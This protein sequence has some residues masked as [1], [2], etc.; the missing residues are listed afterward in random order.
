MDARAAACTPE[1]LRLR[2]N[3]RGLSPGNKDRYFPS[4]Q[5]DTLPLE[6]DTFGE[7][8]SFSGTPGALGAVELITGT[9]AAA[10]RTSRVLI[11]TNNHRRALNYELS[12]GPRFFHGKVK[13]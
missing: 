9:Q 11:H 10:A 5:I 1:R 12:E 3:L 8:V 7:S 6:I 13:S 2:N 4:K